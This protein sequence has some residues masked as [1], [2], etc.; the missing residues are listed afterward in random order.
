MLSILETVMQIETESRFTLIYGNRT[1]ES[2]MFRHDLARL[3]S[4]YADRLEITHV[5]S[6]EPLHT[7]PRCVGGST[8]TGC[9]RC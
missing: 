3:E 2:T 7:P 6:D 8:E 9:N 1:R 5:L 4:R